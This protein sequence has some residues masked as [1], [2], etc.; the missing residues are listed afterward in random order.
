MCNNNNNVDVSYNIQTTVD[1]KNKLIA[2]FKVTTNPNDLGELDNMALRAKT[3]FGAET[4]EVLADKGY[5]KA[6]DLKK[7]VEKHITPYVTKQVYSNG[8]GDRDFYTDRFRY[9]AEKKVYICPAGN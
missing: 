4:L 7:C 9:D 8:T 3:V 6:E 5:Y 2:D 1:A